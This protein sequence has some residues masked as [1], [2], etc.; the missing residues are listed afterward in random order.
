M[1]IRVDSCHRGQVI[2][3]FHSWS[4]LVNSFRR[5]QKSHL[6]TGGGIIISALINKSISD[7]IVEDSSMKQTAEKIASSKK[8]NL[9]ALTPR[10][11]N[12]YRLLLVSCAIQ[13]LPIFAFEASGWVIGSL[14]QYAFVTT[15]NH[16][17]KWSSG[18]W[19]GVFY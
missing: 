7:I 17:L 5:L 3:C 14:G 1:P 8:C 15:N 2:R 6:D 16:R 10:L 11:K 18:E 13:F 9:E 12:I 19:G 4:F